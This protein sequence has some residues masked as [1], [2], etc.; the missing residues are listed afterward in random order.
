MAKQVA[1]ED[2]DRIIELQRKTEELIRELGELHYQKAQISLALD[3]VNTQINSL[4]SERQLVVQTITEKYG[5]GS[6]NLETAEF[7]PEN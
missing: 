7:I 1:K 5:K 3:R 4:E 2:L 6:I